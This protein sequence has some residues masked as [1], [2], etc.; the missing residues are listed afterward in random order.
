MYSNRDEFP[1]SL[2]SVIIGSNFVM[3]RKRPKYSSEMTA[4]WKIARKSH[5][6]SFA[7]VFLFLYSNRFSFHAT[8]DFSD[9]ESSPDLSCSVEFGA[10]SGDTTDREDSTS[11]IV[12]N[13]NKESLLK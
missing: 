11:S 6:R 2:I 12:L 3:D 9:R 8:M 4:T 13:D 7:G 10:E 5:Q 1:S